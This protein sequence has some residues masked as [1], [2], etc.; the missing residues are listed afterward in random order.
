MKPLILSL[1]TLAFTTAPAFGHDP[2]F[3]PEFVASITPSYLA[4][5][6]A[7]AGDDLN[8]AKSGAADFLEAMKEAPDQGDAAKESED[9]RKPAQALQGADDIAAARKAFFELS[10]EFST[11]LGHVGTIEDDE[12]HLIHCPMAFDNTGA[13]WVQ[14]GKEVNNP[15]FGANMLRCGSPMR[16]LSPREEKT[17]RDH[18][19]GQQEQP[20]AP[21][22]PHHPHHGH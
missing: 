8:N 12:L 6:T 22:Q 14:V 18:H 1:V 19:H 9:L 5:Q 7:L 13:R 20:H 11:L 3:K 15:Y 21:Q 17:H 16:Q 10:L 2:A 4:M